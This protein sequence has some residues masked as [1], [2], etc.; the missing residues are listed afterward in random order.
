M[1]RELLHWQ[2]AEDVVALLQ[3]KAPRLAQILVSNPGHYRIGAMLPDLPYYYRGGLSPFDH[4]AEVLHGAHGEDPYDFIR[5]HRERVFT[6]DRGKNERF[7][8][9]FAGIVTHNIVDALF[10]P[11]LY[12][13]TGDYYDR[14]RMQRRSARARHRAFEVLLDR[15]WEIHFGQALQYR[16]Y[17]PLITET[18][19]SDLTLLLDPLDYTTTEKWR[20]GLWHMTY[21]QEIFNAH[22]FGAL[23]HAISK[24]GGSWWR[25]WEA[26]FTYGRTDD[27]IALDTPFTYAQPVTGETLT[28]T[29]HQL[30]ISSVAECVRILTPWQKDCDADDYSALLEGEIARSLNAGLVHTENSEMTFFAKHGGI[31]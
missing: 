7:I 17:R 21:F 10:H 9:L 14:D 16:R 18:L 13:L 1:P 3:Q 27:T 29:W 12:Y 20:S 30:A 5:M 24:R 28:V 31:A 11:P 26:L 25:Q 2:V 6:R 22:T 19:L 15:S 23:M 8:A 4:V